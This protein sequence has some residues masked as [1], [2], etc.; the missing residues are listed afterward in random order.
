M[1]KYSMWYNWLYWNFDC[2][3][4]KVT[5]QLIRIVLWEREGCLCKGTGLIPAP[6]GEAI[7]RKH[8]NPY[9]EREK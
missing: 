2:D 6:D 1:N 7:C 5:R 9:S 4:D 3:A 8:W